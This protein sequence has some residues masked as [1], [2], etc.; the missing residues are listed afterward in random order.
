MT[1]YAAGSIHTHT[2]GSAALHSRFDQKFKCDEQKRN[3]AK[4]GLFH[5]VNNCRINIIQLQGIYVIVGA[6]HAETIKVVHK[7]SFCFDFMSR[8][9]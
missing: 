1:I 2:Q 4:L 8:S 5:G 6:K 3:C 9:C 7:F